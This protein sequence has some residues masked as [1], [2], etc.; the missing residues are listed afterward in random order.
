MQ[1]SSRILTALAVL[2]LAVAVVAVRAGSP[3]VTVEAA[4]GTIDVLNVGTCYTTNDDV[5]AVGDCRDGHEDNID[6]AV[7]SVAGRTTITEVDTG[8]SIYATYAIDPKTSGEA[9]RAILKY[10]DLIHISIEDEGRDKRTGILYGVGATVTPLDDDHRTEIRSV[11]KDTLADE[12]VR[13]VDDP[14][15]PSDDTVEL[16]VD[17]DGN[18]ANFVVRQGTGTTDATIDSSGIYRLNLTGDGSTSHPMAPRGDGKIVWFGCLAASGTG[19][20]ITTGDTANFMDLKNHLK[21]DEDLASG[22]RGSIAPWMRVEASVPSGQQVNIL[23]IYYQTSDR[24]DLVGG[25]RE[26][27]KAENDVE[28]GAGDL[29]NAKAPMFEG[30][31]VYHETN[32]ANPDALVLGAGSDGDEVEQNL[33][34]KETGDFSGVYEGYLR[35]TDADGVGDADGTTEGN[36]RDNWGLDVMN[37]SSS[38]MD[39]A[40]VL[41]VESGPVT[42]RYKNS[43]GDT[44]TATILIDK[45][46]PAIQIDAPAHDTS[47]KDDSP[48]LLG[49]FTDGG[50]AGLRAN[51]FKVYADNKD[52]TDDTDPVWDF[53]VDEMGGAYGYVCIDVDDEAGCDDADTVALRGHYAGYADDADDTSD[54]AETFGIIQSVDVYLSTDDTTDDTDDADD[55]KT[56]SAEDYEDGDTSGLFDS[57]VRIDFPPREENDNRYNN[58]IDIQAVVLDIAGNYGFSDSQPSDPTFIHDYGTEKKDRKGDIHNVLGWYSRHQYRL[59]DVDP[60]YMQKQSATGFFTNED[61]DETTSKSGLKIVFDGAI[62][63]A[64]VGNDTFVVKLDSGSTATVTGVDVDGRNVYLMLEETL[65][66][67]ATPEVDLATGSSILDLAGNESTDRRLDGIELNDGILPSFTITLSGGSGL[68][69][70]I[71]GEGPS[72]LTRNQMTISIESDEDIQGAPQF[73]VVCSNLTWGKLD[74]END[75]AAFAKNRKGAKEN[76]NMAG[77][78]EAQRAGDD[79][80]GTDPDLRTT[81]DPEKPD[82]TPPKATRTF[83][84]VATTSA[85]ARPGNRWEYLWANLSGDQEIKADGKLSVIVWG[86]DRSSYDKDDKGTKLYNYSSATATF[87]YDTELMEAWGGTDGSEL[88]PD[89]GNN[90]FEPRPFVLLDFGDEETTVNVTKFEVD[91]VDHTADLQ[92][93]D[94][95]EFVWWPD[96]L[97]YGKYTVYVE[98]NDAA[99]NTG[100]HT[101]SFTVKERAPFTLSL[102][103]GWNSISFPA[104][105]IDSALHAVFTNAEIDQVIGWNQTEPVSPWRMATRVD[106]VWTTNDEYATLNDIEAR[107]GY[108]VHSSG[109]VTQSVKLSGKGDRAT[110]GQPSPADIPTDEGWNFVG[111][112]DVDGDQ[113]QDDA[114]ETLRNSDN[115]PITAAEYL[116][117]YTRAYT[118]D[119]VNNKWDVVKK[120]EGIT[121]GTGVWVY[122][123]KDHDIAP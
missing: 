7:Y 113:T 89:N 65:P 58:T 117:N 114:G 6:D 87:N 41:G 11:L 26:K 25:A 88:V 77:P 79:P 66:P 23:Y 42:I 27:S 37:A 93:L 4:T 29:M 36:Q 101:Y 73:S 67:D 118:W 110:D 45:D 112:V 8:S 35:L 109:F 97:A 32:N 9:P 69:E 15:D 18:G 2:I 19:T 51:S 10:S 81:C 48:D 107:Y 21:L 99:N 123:T 75:V 16:S 28:Y 59:D 30:D 34:L 76:L 104:N 47:S 24:E 119:H 39:G 17:S 120:D 61:G 3:G 80:T 60:K 78:T 64:S 84:N 43:N 49:T 38:M 116:G 106:G 71:D 111:V 57:V 68:N 108:W 53:G 74:D 40:A 14:A 56:A 83:F 70:D 55:Y 100:D 1:L 86:R 94:D 82:A 12:L 96:P 95:N 85:L 115:D 92:I 50:G 72:E 44:R 98:A 46:P 33:W 90:V 105:P 5:F 52:D 54:K 13:D 22:T 91:K 63:A 102:L 121:I 103:A 20:C 62:D 122:Y 31:E